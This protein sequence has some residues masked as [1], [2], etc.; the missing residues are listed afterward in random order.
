MSDI[1]HVLYVSTASR[2]MEP[3][4]LTALLETARTIN[5]AVGITGL[6]LYRSG[7]FLQH[8][9]GPSAAVHEL[10]ERIKRDPRHFG[11]ITIREGVLEGRA[12]ASWS[13]GFDNLTGI[14]P[15][16]LNGYSDFLRSGFRDQMVL[17]D[18]PFLTRFLKHFAGRD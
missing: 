7:N 17:R 18:T 4:E 16:Q 14:D 15:E 8:F 13:M 3:A 2:L 10:H 1:S 9:E 12:F 6:L 11:V 5:A